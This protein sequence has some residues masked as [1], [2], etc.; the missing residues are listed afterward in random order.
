LLTRRVLLAALAASGCVVSLRG[1]ASAQSY[2]SGPIRIIVPFAAGSAT[3]TGARHIADG[4]SKKWGTPV[5]VENK[6]GANGAIAAQEVV[7]SKPDGYTIFVASNTA[8]ASNVALFNKLPYDPVTQLEPVSS[9]GFAPTFLIAHPS[10][11]AKTL[12]ELIAYAKANPGKINFGSGSASTHMSGEMLKARAGIDIVHIPYRST[13]LALKDLMGGHIH[14]MFADPVTSMPQVRSGTVNCLGVATNE[15]Y[16][17]TP[18]LPTLKEQGIGDFELFTWTAVYLPVGVPRPVYDKIRE[19]VVEVI[20]D[21]AYV[22]RQAGNGSQV[23]TVSPEEMRR[24]QLAEIQLY[25]DLMKG[26]GIEPE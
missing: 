5:V 19:T 26:A 7:R 1:P 20:N 13:P 10:V 14:I 8:I 22:Q 9:I 21:P 17:L 16:K 4:L 3:D 18:D 11:P 24:I 15:R 25:R 6:P 23:R 2:P 12:P